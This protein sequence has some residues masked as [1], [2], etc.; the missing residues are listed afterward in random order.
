MA[1][2]LVGIIFSSF[3]ELTHQ[4]VSDMKIFTT[5]KAAVQHI[6]EKL[7]G[8]SWFYGEHLY[9]FDVFSAIEWNTIEN[10]DSIPVLTMYL[11]DLDK[12]QGTKYVPVLDYTLK[13]FH[14]K[15]ER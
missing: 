10:I 8:N 15:V 13:V 6:A 12:A 9:E 5:E 3:P 1:T 4:E 2:N 11:G 14:L 7:E